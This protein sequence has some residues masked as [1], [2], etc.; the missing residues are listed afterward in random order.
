[1]KWIKENWIY[2]LIILIV[3]GYLMGERQKDKERIANEAIAP[4]QEQIEELQDEIRDLKNQIDE[5]KHELEDYKYKLEENNSPVYYTEDDDKT[6]YISSS[7]IIHKI[8]DCSGM[9]DY[10]VMSYAEAIEDGYRLCEDCGHLAFGTSCSGTHDPEQYPD[11]TILVF[12][13]S[14]RTYHIDQDCSKFN[15]NQ[16][17]DVMSVEDAIRSGYTP[18]DKCCQ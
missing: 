4:Y 15:F 8:N 12:T 1:M 7:G 2:I 3:I 9:E 18:C 11:D 5:Y 17:D 6:V 13:C 16:N 10:E 14:N